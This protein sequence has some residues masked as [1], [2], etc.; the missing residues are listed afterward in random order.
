[1]QD[2]HDQKLLFKFLGEIVANAHEKSDDL[3]KRQLEKL[4]DWISAQIY[5]VDFFLWTMARHGYTLQKSRRHIDDFS[6][7]QERVFVQYRQYLF[8]QQAKELKQLISK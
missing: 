8:D 5:A 7:I 1:M 6:D 2:F 3:G 4:P